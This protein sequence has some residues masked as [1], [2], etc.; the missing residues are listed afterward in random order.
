LPRDDQ[1]GVAAV[2]AGA[3]AAAAG[4]EAA[5]VTE[6][7]WRAAVTGEAAAVVTAE[8][9]GAVEVT[10]GRG[11]VADVSTN[12]LFPPM[13]ADPHSLDTNSA[14]DPDPHVFGPPGSGSFPFLIKVL[15]GLK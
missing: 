1:L 11:G 7:G 2:A 4:G 15:S 12:V 6:T 13:V 8:A 3:V 9:T 14:G 10:E 5:A